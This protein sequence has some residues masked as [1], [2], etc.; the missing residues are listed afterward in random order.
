MPEQT[1]RSAE[2]A[3]F[4]ESYRLSDYDR[5]SV[6]TDVAAFSIRSEKERCYRKDSRINL[7]LLLI[8]RGAH[9]F[10]NCWAL[11][12]GFVRMEETLEACAN[13]EL[14]EETNLDAAA[15]IPVGTFSAPDRDPRGRIISA[16]YTAIISHDEANIRGGEDA[17]EAKWFA[18]RFNRETS[19]EHRLVLE[20]EDVKLEARLKVISQRFGH[21]RYEIL[22]NEGLAFDHAGII[23]SAL[24]LLRYEAERFAHVFDF[25]PER[26]TLA[27]LQQVQETLMS[28]SLTAAN[29]RR[30]ASEFVEE[31]EEFTEGAGH[32]P[33]RLYRRKG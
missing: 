5:P 23:A 24:S 31:T 33:A 17:L 7:A 26:F 13:R 2:E 25:L 9:P 3:S 10:R 27:Q 32:R 6:A 14:R 12:G 11:P 16:A 22:E 18:V 4:L 20:W 19:D 30:K 21:V 15:L 1:G 29:F 28:T 8:R